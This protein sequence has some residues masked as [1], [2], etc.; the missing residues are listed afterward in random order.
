MRLLLPL[1]ASVT[2]PFPVAADAFFLARRAQLADLPAFHR[3]PAAFR[4]VIL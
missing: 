4:V 3:V 1:S 2:T